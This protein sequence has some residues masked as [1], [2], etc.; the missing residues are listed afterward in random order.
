[1]P[2]FDTALRQPL[3]ILL[4]RPRGAG[5]DHLIAQLED[6]GFQVEAEIVASHP[7]F[8]EKLR[9][10]RFDVAINGLSLANTSKMVEPQR[11]R[12]D[13]AALEAAG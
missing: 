10:G 11:R 1:M 8:E 12:A 13:E 4:L 2:D 7:A 5:A 9:S 6:A 3:K